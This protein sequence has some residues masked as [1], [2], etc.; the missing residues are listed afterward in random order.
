MVISLNATWQ[1]SFQIGNPADT[2]W[3]LIA[4]SLQMKLKAHRNDLTAALAISTDDG[5][6]LI[7]DAV[8]RIFSFNVSPTDLQAAL[9]PDTYDYDLLIVT[10][11]N[12]MP[13]MHGTVCVELGIT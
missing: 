1:D 2:S 6:I 5:R 7:D 11:T 9:V 3:N 10:A 12:T 4:S 13:V 8:A